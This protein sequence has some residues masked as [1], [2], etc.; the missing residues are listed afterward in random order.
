MPSPNLPDPDKIPDMSLGE[1]TERPAPVQPTPP[2]P[3]PPES[4]SYQHE[5]VIDP[6]PSSRVPADE[7]ESRWQEGDDVLAPWEPTM[8]YP[9]TI[10]QIKPDDARG[11]QALIAYDDGGEGWVFLYSLCPLEFKPGQR[12]QVRREGGQVYFPA[13][14][15][16][17]SGGEVRVNYHEGGVA[18]T[19][20][21]NLRRECIANGPAAVPVSFAPWQ[22]QAPG[23]PAG[24]GEGSGIPSWVIWIGIF[25]LLTVFRI[26]CRAAMQ[27]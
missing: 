15:L 6:R 14:I 7:P 16:E 10:K 13:E 4:T 1:R 8:L 2:E 3:L 26:G 19:R 18:W 21:S 25:I 9:G 22:T 24:T 23:L 11:D 12:V 5:P 27:N 17:V 20:M